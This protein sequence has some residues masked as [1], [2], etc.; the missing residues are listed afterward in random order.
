[1]PKRALRNLCV[2]ESVLLSHGEVKTILLDERYAP[3]AGQGARLENL[4]G[5][6][7]EQV[8]RAL[9]I[10]MPIQC[11]VDVIGHRYTLPR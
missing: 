2:P 7:T 11:V 6:F 1:M 9:I 4:C 3:F 10:V 8:W 5:S